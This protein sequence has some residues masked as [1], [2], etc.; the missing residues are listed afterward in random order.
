[1]L[2]DQENQKNLLLAIVLSMAVLMAWQFLYV[3]PR[4]EE[5]RQA[6]LRLE[7]TKAKEKQATPDTTKTDPTTKTDQ[8]TKTPPGP[9]ST[10]A[11][12]L[13]RQAALD[14]SPRVGIDSPSFKGSISLKGGR[15]DDLV[16][17]KYRESV[18]PKSP[19]VVLFAPSRSP[20]PYYAEYGWIAGPGVKQPMPD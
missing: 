16:L 9:A 2:N 7:Q 10:T 6:R 20:H 18:D 14:A 5:E 12:Q 3:W 8:T 13:T 17:A 1:M 19:H 11:P 4:Q 15:I